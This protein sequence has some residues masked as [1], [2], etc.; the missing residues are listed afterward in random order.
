M[1][2]PASAIESEPLGDGVELVSVRGE[3]DLFVAPELKRAIAGAVDDGARGVIVDLSEA[4][5]LDSSALGVMLDA[6]R[7]VRA[8]D[9]QLV[10]VDPT[11]AVSRNFEIAGVDQ[12]LDICPT[13]DAALTALETL[14]ADA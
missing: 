6:L 9:G 10:V 8:R 1:T 12:I 7:R 3:L 13:R 14:P 5:F 11:Q 2:E 4:T